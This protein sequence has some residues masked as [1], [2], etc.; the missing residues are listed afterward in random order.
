MNDRNESEAARPVRMSRRRALTLGGLGAIGVVMG[1]CLPEPAQAAVLSRRPAFHMTPPAGWLCDPQRPIRF[2]GRTWLYYLHSDTNSGDGGWDVAT[3]T[4]LV[5]FGDNSVAIPV[6][7]DF[8]VWT[9]SAVVDEENTAGFGAGAIVVLATQPT[10][11]VR[12]RQE[13]YLYW[14]TDGRSFQRLESP[15]IVNPDGD[16][17]VTAEEIDNAEWFRDPKVVRDDERDQWVCGIGRR[18][19]ASLYTSRDLRTWTW[20]SNF[21]Y[22]RDGTPDLGGIECPDLFRITADD[23]TSHWVLGASMD[24][25][26]AGLPMTY[27][28]WVG[29]WDGSAFSTATTVPQWLDWG[30][31]WYAAVTWPSDTDPEHERYAFAWMNNWKYAARDVPTDETDRF[32]GQGS[33]VRSL[34]LQKQRGGWYTLLS[35]PIPALDSVAF[36][37]A[38][39]LADRDVAGRV[40]FERTGRAYSLEV[41][42]DWSDATNVGVAVGSSVDDSRHTNIGVFNGR[43]YVDRGPS[44]ISDASFLPYGQAEAPIDPEARHV[45]LR[46]L[47]DQQSVEVFVNDGFTVLSQQVWFS[48]GDERVRLYSYGGSARF[49]SLRWRAAS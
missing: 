31:D 3:T 7:P 27:A 23:G 34:R 28:Y 10:G 13:Q 45:H 5:R 36:T 4:D 49:S 8:P 12:R 29:D 1:T 43:V 38:E 2:Q 40:E 15:V 20:T 44:D 9:G 21:D 48:E 32:N 30:W 42:I 35:A 39:T 26:G 24:A 19:Y 37:P 22:L 47:V 25:Y 46:V 6:L 14:S 33:V 11:G 41:D 18:R 16:S 17:A